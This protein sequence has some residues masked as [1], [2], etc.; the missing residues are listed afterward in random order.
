[1][2]L[3]KQ[4]RLEK[5]ENWFCLN[6][7]RK[8]FG[9]RADFVAPILPAGSGM[10]GEKFKIGSGAA[11]LDQVI[12]FFRLPGMLA[13]LCGNHVDLAAAGGKCANA[14]PNAEQAKFSDVAK[15]EIYTPPVGTAVLVGTR[16]RI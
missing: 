13:L 16:G 6:G 4:I 15:I 11:C 12:D 5:V 2:G 9:I 3:L 8:L 1:M 14:S 10:A 7:W